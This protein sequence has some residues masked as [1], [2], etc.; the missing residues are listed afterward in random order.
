MSL[1]PA[2][3]RTLALAGLVVAAAGVGAWYA[4]RPAPA[5]PPAVDLTGADPEV[6]AAVREAT[7][8][9]TRSSRDAAAWGKLGMVLRAHDFG[10]ESVRALRE[11]ER[12]DPADPRWP[13]L[14]GLTLL[15]AAPDEG[16]ACLERAA[17]TPAAPPEVKLRLA[18]ALLGRGRTEEAEALARA[19]RESRPG[20][21][22]AGLVLA[23]VAAARA[24]WDA[25]LSLTD[26][27]RD[28]PRCAK[29]VALLRGQ[30]LAR[31][32]RAADAAAELKRAAELPDDPGWADPVVREVMRLQVGTK[33]LV[34]EAEGLI[35]AG[36]PR[37]A[38]PL[39]ERA[40]RQNPGAA[41]P[42]AELGRALVLA[43]DPA[44][45]RSVL[46]ELT[47]QHPDSVDGWF[48]LGVAQF[49]LGDAA[50][51]AESFAT[52]VR[53]KPDHAL[54]HFNLAHARRKLGD[55]PGA[56]A[57][58]EE[59]LRCRPDY[60]AARHLLRELQEGK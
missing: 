17:R 49:Q 22:R 55:R 27:L 16:L 34:Q 29:Q 48:H 18:E 56:I 28:E 2:R 6:A 13:Y 41:A 3:R 59:A 31:A 25:T 36:E 44:A 45:A 50:A 51:A 24:D 38:V 35:V 37:R 30:A 43:N 21:A 40:V 52:V 10:N 58:A 15:L 14:Q 12:L 7:E 20:N 32:G 60:E 19:V 4:L 57:A 8:E 23:R 39:L 5:E 1:P 26:G 33:T 53:L 46:A 9:V 11:A 54:G 42:R 47:R